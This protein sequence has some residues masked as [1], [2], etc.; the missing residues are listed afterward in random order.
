MHIITGFLLAGVASS[1]RS[2][3]GLAGLPRFRT[4]PL[5]VAHAVPGRLRLVAPS[6]RGAE[7]ADAAWTADMA[8]LPG[9]HAV[10]ASTVSGSIVVVY[11]A[12]AVDAPLVFGT[13]AR[14]LGVE[15]A[16]QKA[17]ESVVAH[18]LRD[19]GAS[20]DQ[21]VHD[22]THGLLDG[23]TA[24]LLAV[25]VLGIRQLATAGWSTPPAVTLLWWVL[26]GLSR[27]PG[28]AQ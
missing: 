4:G 22:A 5:R 19:L 12:G 8:S 7:P 14:F 21:A 15:E 27:G 13:V 24:L 2:Q 23:R 26:N 9:V 20:V 28:T 1:L 6:L 10:T 25:L 11:D 17:P 16:L 3:R 18:E